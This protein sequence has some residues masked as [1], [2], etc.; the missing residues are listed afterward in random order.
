[1]IGLMGCAGPAAS[2]KQ[3]EEYV[4]PDPVGPIVRENCQAIA[5]KYEAAHVESSV[6]T[7]SVGAS[8]SYKVEAIREAD[9]LVSIL[10]EQRVGLCN[11]FN[12]CKLTVGEYREEKRVLDDS[13]VALMAVR[14]QLQKVD[15]DGAVKLMQ[16]LR[17]IRGGVAPGTAQA[18]ASASPAAP[19]PES[20]AAGGD[21]RAV[22][23]PAGLPP[24]AGQPQ[25]FSCKGFT[26]QVARRDS[27]MG[28]TYQYPITRQHLSG[29]A[30]FSEVKFYEFE[31]AT[32]TLNGKQVE[33]L[34]VA[35][36]P[37]MSTMESLRK[38]LRGMN[39]N[40]A[41]DISCPSIPPS[42]TLDLTE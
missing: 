22:P 38:R 15:P 26:L 21:D 1:M 33:Y 14:D 13:Y 3:Y 6:G 39:A 36:A 37:N 29:A 27:G 28:P 10:K 25:A 34:L 9:Q 32:E 18:A 42:R 24:S 41:M 2:Q 16:E 35:D 11:D 8:A 30:E 12:T 40:A 17:S 19:S 5:L 31:L 7:Q 23:P 4:C 20:A